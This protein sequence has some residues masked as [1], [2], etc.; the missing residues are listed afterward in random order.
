MLD[1]ILA[2]ILKELMLKYPGLAWASIYVQ[3]LDAFKHLG[4]GPR[5]EFDRWWQQEMDVPFPGMEPQENP[6]PVYD[7]SKV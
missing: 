7:P 3:V 2:A 1:A 4:P 6:G 5:E